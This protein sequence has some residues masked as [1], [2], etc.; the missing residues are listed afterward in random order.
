MRLKLYTKCPV[1][2]RTNEPLETTIQNNFVIHLKQMRYVCALMEREGRAGSEACRDRSEA[3][4][5]RNE[6]CRAGSEA[7]RAGSEV[8]CAGSEVCC[9]GSEACRAG[10]FLAW[11]AIHASAACLFIRFSSLDFCNK[12][13][14]FSTNLH[15]VSAA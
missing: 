9:A 7:C 10:R 6:A 8:C 3:C 2:N 12:A 13:G 11:S 5:V 15:G 14:I 4:R 1:N